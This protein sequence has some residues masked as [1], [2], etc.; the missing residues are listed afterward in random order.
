MGL[1]AFGSGYMVA[2]YSGGAIVPL[3]KRFEEILQIFQR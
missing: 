1:K 2:L 3:A